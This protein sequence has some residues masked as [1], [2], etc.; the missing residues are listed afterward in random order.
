MEIII[1]DHINY[2]SEEIALLV[3]QTL[4]EGRPEGFIQCREFLE[5]QFGS[6]PVLE[7]FQAVDSIL[8]EAG[9]TFKKDAGIIEKYFH[10]Y[11]DSVLCLADA[12]LLFQ[13]WDCNERAD[14][15]EAYVRRQTPSERNYRFCMMNIENFSDYSGQSA[16]SVTL[17]DVSTWLDQSPLSPN[18]K[19]EIFSAFV[20]WEEHLEIIIRLMKKAEAVLEKTKAL[21]QPLVTGFHQYWQEQ[22]AHQDV[23]GDIVQ[24]FHID[25][26]TDSQRPVFLAPNVI[27]INS[28]G[29]SL[30]DPKY[31][32]P[33]DYYSIGILYGKALDL[34]F[35]MQLKD[36]RQLYTCL[37]F[38][39]LLSDKS[40]LE[41]MASITKQPAYGAQLAR[42][43]NLT[44]ATI[45]YHM[46]ALIMEGLVCVHRDSKRLY[47][48]VNKDTVKKMLHYLEVLLL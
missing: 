24:K 46:N 39:K 11:P 19:W 34:D 41:I 20:K 37:Q 32:C 27:N 15:L 35:D 33:W 4:P 16:D 43:M 10:P 29:C 9:R 23:I 22:C 47:Y 31:P 2:I 7:R 44:T 14:T 26:R 8:K 40:K 3:S 38:L 1:S 28:F 18:D 6:S 36:G 42:Q 5:R 45:S 25:L 13:K 48:S 17:A 12:V 21:W 30:P